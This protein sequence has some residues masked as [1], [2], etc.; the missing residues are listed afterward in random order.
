M[1]VPAQDLVVA[2]TK[3]ALDEVSLPDDPNH[4]QIPR[5]YSDVARLPPKPAPVETPLPTDV[6]SLDG[7]LTQPEPEGITYY[8][9]L[10]LPVEI[11]S[12]IFCWTLAKGGPKS[13][14]TSERK[15]LTL[16]HICHWWRRIAHSTP[17]LWTTLSLTTGVAQSNPYV[18]LISGR[19]FDADHIHSFLSRAG[20]LP[21]SISIS[22][23]P[24]FSLDALRMAVDMILPYSRT[25]KDI[26]ISARANPI[27]PLQAIRPELPQLQSLELVLPDLEDGK[28]HLD[29]DDLFGTM[30]QTALRLRKLH[31]V[32]RDYEPIALPWAQ[33]TTLQLDHFEAIR[34]SD[35]LDGTPNLVNLLLG[36]AEEM[37]ALGRLPPLQRLRS[38]LFTRSDPQLQRAILSR[39]NAQLRMLKMAV[40]DLTP[41][42]LT[43]A[44]PACLEELEV[45][46]LSE[47]KAG[48]MD[49]LVAMSSLRA[50]KIM[51]Y[52]YDGPPPRVY[53][54]AIIARLTNDRA[55]LPV[56]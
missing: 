14:F 51:V 43:M 42:T 40:W 9:V 11:T 19:P 50:L 56:L 31:L 55:F 26:S 21:L 10:A 27:Y 25:W 44:H 48:S 45:D 18:Q 30:F 49:G 23:K 16:C 5:L 7:L 33:L 4:A 35:I 34:L 52:E 41:G 32:N 47:A 22:V 38:L 20:S 36:S 3:N 46:Y 24:R 2:E 12:Q 17:E 39:L 37:W 6:P 1:V 15:T 29:P 13:L 28:I 8:P 54:R 53:L